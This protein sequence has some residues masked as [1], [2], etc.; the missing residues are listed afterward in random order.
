MWSVSEVHPESGVY[1]SEYASPKYVDPSLEYV[2][3]MITVWSAPVRSTS[4]VLGSE[5]GVRPK[6]VFGV[7]GSEHVSP[8]NVDRSLG[9]RVCEFEVRRSES[10]VN[11]KYGSSLEYVGLK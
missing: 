2:R 8:N 11:P 3:S 9:I 6:C 7:C 4:E 10:G 1:R 5:S